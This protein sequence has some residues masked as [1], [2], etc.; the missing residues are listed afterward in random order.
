MNAQPAGEFSPNEPNER[1]KKVGN[2]PS[3]ELLD[4]LMG[5]P[6]ELAEYFN[7]TICE[8]Y[9]PDG[10]DEMSSETSQQ[11][12][13]TVRGE[14][15]T[16]EDW[17]NKHL[18]HTVDEHRSLVTSS[19]ETLPQRSELSF[20]VINQFIMP[21][22]RRVLVSP[23]DPKMDAIDLE[24]AQIRLAIESVSLLPTRD[25]FDQTEVLDNELR[26]IDAMIKLLQFSI[27]GEL[28]NQP[29]VVTVPHPKMGSQHSEAG[30]L[31]FAPTDNGSFIKTEV[32]LSEVTDLAQ[33][34]GMGAVEFLNNLRIHLISSRPEFQSK[35]EFHKFIL[36]HQKARLLTKAQNNL[37]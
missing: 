31:I 13:R 17:L 26:D 24:T 10:L 30:F 36:A 19:P 28:H 22:W 25:S 12:A 8:Q 5:H 9:T 16:Y 15:A 11:A 35:V 23:K 27:D 3:F 6:R 20:H 2:L 7:S 14:L 37:S 34:P 32:A 18:I 4:N 1:Q 21:Q 29:G 33:A